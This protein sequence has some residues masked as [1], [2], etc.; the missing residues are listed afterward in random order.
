MS[1]SLVK[2][3]DVVR[4]PSFFFFSIS[5]RRTT[6][7]L[8]LFST[9]A[10][11][12]PQYSNHTYISTLLEPQDQ[13]TATNNSSE[14]PSRD[15]HPTQSQQLVFPPI[16]YPV[17]MPAPAVQALNPLM[18]PVYV[19]HTF[20]GGSVGLPNTSGPVQTRMPGQRGSDRTKDRKPRTCQV[21]KEKNLPASRYSICPGRVHRSRCETLNDAGRNHN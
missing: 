3:V 9:L 10:L 5:I 20:I 17:A 19:N 4:R 6:T 2:C 18:A 11:D 13:L 16:R 8:S 14:R 1:Q 7:T 12:L 15:T 21:C